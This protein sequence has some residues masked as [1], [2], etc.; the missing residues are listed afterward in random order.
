MAS[1][2][3]GNLVLASFRTKSRKDQ[4]FI[5]CL[6]EEERLWTINPDLSGRA[7][8][9]CWVDGDFW[10]C[11]SYSD[12]MAFGD[13]NCYTLNQTSIFLLRL[14]ANGKPKMLLSP[15]GNAL[16][17][18]LLGKSDG[19]VLLYG[20][21]ADSLKLKDTVLYTDNLAGSAFLGMIGKDGNYRWSKSISGRIIKCKSDGWYT[22]L[23]MQQDKRLTLKTIDEYGRMLSEIPIQS[24][25]RRL[26]DFAIG[27][28]GVISFLWQDSDGVISIE[29]N[30]LMK[31]LSE[32]IADPNA[33]SLIEPSGSGFFIS[34]NESP[35]GI[36][37][38]RKAYILELDSVGQVKSQWEFSGDPSFSIRRLVSTEKGLFYSGHCRRLNSA[39]DSI[40][41][42]GLH[43]LFV[44]KL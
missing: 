18:G 12:F 37:D 5:V 7:T 9:V 25:N 19:G 30:I 28:G 41:Y 35:N 14:D 4:P 32:F 43:N 34:F 23:L 11:G 31:S 10:V 17:Q 3:T 8:S 27:E 20:E 15:G 21:Y 26:K 1:D 44:G 16:P 13:L 22:Q 24:T 38:N 6:S 40:S 2:D 29:N 33:I 36:S 39:T 42:N